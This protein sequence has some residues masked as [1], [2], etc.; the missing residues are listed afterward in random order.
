MEIA[1]VRTTPSAQLHELA[2]EHLPFFGKPQ[3]TGLALGFNL[4]GRRIRL[5]GLG[6]RGAHYIARAA[7]RG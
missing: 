4:H 1:G 5:W 2:S 6:D 7:G 3:A